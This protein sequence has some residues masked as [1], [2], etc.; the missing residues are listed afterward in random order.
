[1]LPSAL[2]ADSLTLPPYRDKAQLLNEAQSAGLVVPRLYRLG[3]AHNNCGGECVKGGQAQWIRLL[4]I[5]PD[6]YARAEAAELV[7]RFVDPAVV[8]ERY[9]RL[10]RVVE[11]SGRRTHEARVGRV[12]E[13]LVE[14]PS[15]TNPDVLTGRTAQNKLVHFP[16]ASPIRTG[17]YALVEVTGAAAHHLQGELRKVVHVATH[18][19]RIPVAAS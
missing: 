4:R 14:G 9:E 16:S 19:T 13:V 10:R 12:E 6:R 1:M 2:L 15:R 3:F 8:G 17:S 7:D 11:R 5:F 18:K